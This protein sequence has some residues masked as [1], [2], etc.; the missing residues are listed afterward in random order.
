MF[1]K[2]KKLDLLF[3]EFF[4]V[5]LIHVGCGS[6]IPLL[7]PEISP[8]GFFVTGRRSAGQWWRRKWVFYKLDLHLGGLLDYKLVSWGR[9]AS[10]LGEGNGTCNESSICCWLRMAEL[11]ARVV[12]SVIA[13]LAH[14]RHAKCMT[15]RDNLCACFTGAELMVYCL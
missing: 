14:R 4:P 7:V 10:L 6:M 11:L 2:E 5:I 3:S 13:A 8:S 1:F 15:T 9:Y 12:I